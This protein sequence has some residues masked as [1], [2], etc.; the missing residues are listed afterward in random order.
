[1]KKRAKFFGLIFTFFFTTASFGQTRDS[2]VYKYKDPGTATLIS[3]LITGGGQF[4][5]GESGKGLFLMG[6]SL[7]AVLL[8]ASASDAGTIECDW[9]DCYTTDENLT[10][11]YLG[12]AT[13]VGLWIYSVADAGSAARRSN[14]RNGLASARFAIKPT[15]KDPFG[16]RPGATL[17][18]RF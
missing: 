8:G 4:Y 12:V 5:A 16:T 9:Y 13:A 2:A 15:I 1:M 10:P 14:E 11:F 17:S 6:G 7:A 18:I 3:V